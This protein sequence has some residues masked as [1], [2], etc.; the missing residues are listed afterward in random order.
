MNVQLSDAANPIDIAYLV[1]SI[2]FILGLKFLSS[3]ATARKGNQFAGVGMIIAVVAT[4]FNSEIYHKTVGA[5]AGPAFCPYVIIIGIIVGGLIGF[6]SASKVKMT[7]M[8][9]MVALFNG[10]GGGA[11]ALVATAEFVH[12]IHVDGHLDTEQSI[13]ILLTT[14]IGSLSI[15]GSVVAFLKLQEL[16]TGRPITYPGQKIVNG[17]VLLIVL[18]SSVAAV[19]GV[20][21]LVTFAAA[22][23]LALFLGVFFVLPIGGADMPVVISLLNAFTGVAVS[24]TGFV[25]NNNVLIISGALVG[26]SGTLLTILMGQAMNRP[27]SNVLF[28]AFGSGEGSGPAA[29]SGADANIRSASVDDVA[30]MLSYAQQVIIVPGYGMAVAQ[31]QHAVKNLATQLENK[32]VIVKYAIHPVAGRMPGHMNVLLAEADVP[33]PALYDMED[34]NPDFARTD[35]ALVIGANDVTNPAARSD[36]SSPIYGMPILDVDQA[37]NIVVL[38]RSMRS[39]FA[40]IPNPLYEDP[41][42]VMLFGDAKDSV[43][44]LASAVKAL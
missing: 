10:A 43:E 36:K 6:V 38:K 21:P 42:T 19:L 28:G 3:P 40:G 32:G 37:Q 26:A 11:A 23:V 12:G 29:G 4:L 35:V 20:D 25:L 16:M 44:K 34:I 33:Y 18:A 30:T 31:A 2:L 39:G 27:I 24:V 41:K 9:Q 14:I 1:T 22:G 8:P 13:A 17:L 7:A 5:V 15:A